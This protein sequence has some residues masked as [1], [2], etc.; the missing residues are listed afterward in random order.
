MDGV[1]EVYTCSY[2]ELYMTIGA[3]MMPRNSII[4]IMIHVTMAIKSSIRATR[5]FFLAASSLP[6]F[7]SLWAC[8][9][10]KIA[11]IVVLVLTYGFGKTDSRNQTE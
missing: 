8:M 10:R 11:T 3:T 4:T 6:R 9:C 2:A 7:A 1:H 5:A